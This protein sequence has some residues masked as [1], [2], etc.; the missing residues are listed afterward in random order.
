M[1]AV[2]FSIHCKLYPATVVALSGGGV[3]VLYP[4][5]ADWDEWEEQL[6]VEESACIVSAQ[7]HT[8]LSHVAVVRSSQTAFSLCGRACTTVVPSRVQR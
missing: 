2:G 5:T 8:T 7:A 6:A 3:T 4:E 1:G